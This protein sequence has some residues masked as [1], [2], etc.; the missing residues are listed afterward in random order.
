MLQITL[1]L[2]II[3]DFDLWPL[4][5]KDKFNLHPL[6]VTAKPCS[7][8]KSDSLSLSVVILAQTQYESQH[9]PSYVRRNGKQLL[10]QTDYQI[11]NKI[12]AARLLDPGTS[13][14]YCR[15]SGLS[16]RAEDTGGH[17][18]PPT[19]MKQLC[20]DVTVCET[21]LW[22]P[23][24]VNDSIQSIL[25]HGSLLFSIKIPRNTKSECYISCNG[26]KVKAA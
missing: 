16:G 26:I 19:T 22:S 11:S 1:E 15:R 5:K 23:C 6:K 10:C 14:R 17:C 7:S 24:G 3:D 8:C 21:L 4:L 2:Y 9:R 12:V 20:R 13:Q 18:P 25:R